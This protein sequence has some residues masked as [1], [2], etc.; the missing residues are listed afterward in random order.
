MQV[1]VV[2]LRGQN[3]VAV[4]APVAHIEQ[5]RVV[6]ERLA[7]YQQMVQFYYFLQTLLLDVQFLKLLV[8]QSRSLI[9]F[10]VPAL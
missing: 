1:G 8:T 3:L 5:S 6:R 2:G 9:S 7:L 4:A 10:V